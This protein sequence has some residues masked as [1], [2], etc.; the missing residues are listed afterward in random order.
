M[1]YLTLLFTVMLAGCI[2]EPNWKTAD[3]CW[4]LGSQE[5][6]VEYLHEPATI[7]VSG[8]SMDEIVEIC[9]DYDWGCYV[10]DTIYLYWGA[11]K[12]DLYH[13]KCHSMG[14]TEH[15]SCIGYAVWG[16]DEASACP[17]WV[18]ENKAKND[19]AKRYYRYQ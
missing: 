17:D 15:N 18:A 11:G 16:D 8:L 6:P 1:K 14:L 19:Y 10:G 7:I 2:T 3:N 9:G 4:R 13:G 5:I 12:R